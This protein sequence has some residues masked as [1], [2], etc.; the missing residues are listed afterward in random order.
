MH[1][2]SS[3]PH[4]E[5]LA[6]ISECISTSPFSLEEPLVSGPS[7]DTASDLERAAVLRSAKHSLFDNY[8]KFMNPR[9]NALATFETIRQNVFTHRTYTLLL[10]HAQLPMAPEESPLVSSDTFLF[11]VA[12]LEHSLTPAQF[13]GWFLAIFG[14][15]VEASE[16]V[17]DNEIK[18]ETDAEDSRPS[19]KAK[20]E[21]T[22]SKFARAYTS[23][24]LVLELQT[25]ARA[26]RLVHGQRGAVARELPMR[27][28]H[29]SHIIS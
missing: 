8:F 13:A 20:L 26:K 11:Y 2:A 21:L 6:A 29:P 28:S 12:A 19:K 1:T 22:E 18:D 3:A 14:P 27:P 25:N 7:L 17:L 15:L 9:P 4:S 24:C 10:Q 5:I 23:F 16:T